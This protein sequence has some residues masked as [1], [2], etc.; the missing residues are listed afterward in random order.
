MQQQQQQE[1]QQQQQQQ[2]QSKRVTFWA[3]T[4]ALGASPVC[5]ALQY[6]VD[7]VKASAIKSQRHRYLKRVRQGWV[8][9]NIGLYSPKRKNNH[10]PAYNHA[11][12]HG[13][14]ADAVV[15]PRTPLLHRFL[16]DANP[17][18][19]ATHIALI[20]LSEEERKGQLRHQYMQYFDSG[21]KLMSCSPNITRSSGKVER[22]ML[23]A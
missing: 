9:T 5:E 8:P 4:A 6:C 10:T 7:S 22:S 11:V 23:F 12:V 13:R 18:M 21:V 16:Q 14:V 1:Q 2:Q 19:S 20:E 17:W 15:T 3:T